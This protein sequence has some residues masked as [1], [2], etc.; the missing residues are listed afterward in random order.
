MTN[1]QGGRS[2][3]AVGEG[4][5]AGAGQPTP[6]SLLERLRR[7]D[8]EAWR[9]LL[10]LYRPLVLFWCARGGVAVDDAEDV[11]QGVFAGAAAGLHAFRHDRPDD[12]FRGWL[13]ILTRNHI[14]L[15]FRRDRDRVPAEGGS[16]A[17]EKLESVADP[18]AVAREDEEAE[19]NQLHRRAVEQVRGE[20]EERTWQAFWLTA[21]EGRAPADLAAELDMTPT[22]IRQAKSRVLRRLKQ[23]LGDLIH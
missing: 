3:P 20:F 9:R 8:A 14:A 15:H 10:E 2:R 19:V 1:N 4:G 7:N 21:I 17:R 23:E 22:A 16:H 5:K 13:R 12:T 11:T 18:L 6:L